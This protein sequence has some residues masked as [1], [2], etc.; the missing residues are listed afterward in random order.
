MEKKKNKKESSKK[1]TN[2]KKNEVKEKKYLTK[3]N[4]IYAIILLVDIFLV[5]YTARKN[6]VNYV[7]IENKR[8]YIGK[9]YILFF[10]RNYI[11]LLIT[12]IIYAY[13]IILNKIKLKKKHTKKHLIITLIGLFIFN[14]LLFYLF[15]KKV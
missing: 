4:I 10:G 15:T 13:Y 11:T 7:T 8:K 5:I 12:F 2:I 9:K 6:I 1:K 3:E 14:C